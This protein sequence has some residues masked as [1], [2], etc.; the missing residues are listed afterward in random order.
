MPAFEEKLESL[1]FEAGQDLSAKQY[2]FVTQAADGQIDPTGDGGRAD[3]VLQN[4]PAAAGR[5]ATVGVEGTSMVV[6]GGA[7]TAGDN[8]ASN[9]AGRAKTAVGGNA[10][11]GKARTTSTADGQ[12]IAVLLKVQGAPNA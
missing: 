8:V 5:A 1:T 10:V 7:V 11:L 4:A 2:H 12:L 6:A 3:G 9:A